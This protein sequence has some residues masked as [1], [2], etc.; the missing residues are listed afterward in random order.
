VTY[1]SDLKPTAVKGTIAGDNFTINGELS[2]ARMRVNGKLILNGIGATVTPEGIVSVTY[3][4]ERRYR[5]FQAEIAI[6]DGKAF[7]SLRFVVLIDGK[8]KWESPLRKKGEVQSCNISVE[9]GAVLEL[10]IMGSGNKGE[11]FSQGIWIQP[12]LIQ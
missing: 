8:Q 7:V 1:L 11:E 6:N 5:A 9:G 12:Q 4:L 3:S 2:G 10:L